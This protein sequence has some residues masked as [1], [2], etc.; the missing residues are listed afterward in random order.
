LLGWHAVLRGCVAF[1]PS[2]VRVERA[3]KAIDQGRYM[4]IRY[5]DKTFGHFS[6]DY[7][8][9]WP[10]RRGSVAVA[11]TDGCFTRSLVIGILVRSPFGDEVS[12]RL[13][14]SALCLTLLVTS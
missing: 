10:R 14:E 4:L 2:W 9:V 1:R 7:A 6:Y 8:A 3:M 12:R 5:S 11:E 13:R